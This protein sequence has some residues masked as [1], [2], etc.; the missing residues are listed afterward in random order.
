MHKDED[1]IQRYLDELA[2]VG[3]WGLK[4]KEKDCDHEW[5][6][7]YGLTDRYEYCKNCDI[8]KKD[9]ESKNK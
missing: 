2:A 8:K 5:V 9:E 4:F 3:S 1:E 6:F 7:Y